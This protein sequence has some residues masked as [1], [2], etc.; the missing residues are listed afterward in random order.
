MTTK[1]I[2][3]T[4]TGET[5][6]FGVDTDLV[7]PYLFQWKRNG[8]HVGGNHKSYTTP[9]LRPDDFKAKYSVLVYGQ[10]KTEESPPVVMNANMTD[11]TPIT[12]EQKKAAAIIIPPPKAARVPKA[13]APTPKPKKAPAKKGKK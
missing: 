1:V 7:A 8:V 3:P 13:Q 6:T 9:P 12:D 10:D 2:L 5:A 4:A 11:P